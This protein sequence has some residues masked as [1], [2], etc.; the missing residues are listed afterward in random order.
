MELTE[1]IKIFSEQF[2][3]ISPDQ[4]SAETEYKKLEEWDSL[5]VL[6][7][8][9]MVDEEFEVTIT[10]ADLR[11]INTIEELYNFVLESK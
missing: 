4:I 7:V 8:V 9:S 6:S 3:N 11:A 2:E 10:G 1:F 5:A